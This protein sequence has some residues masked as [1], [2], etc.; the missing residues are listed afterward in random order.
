M[1]GKFP[2]PEMTD[3]AQKFFAMFARIEFAMKR[4]PAF[5]FDNPLE[6]DWTRLGGVL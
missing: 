3:V 6:P 4:C 5:R 1:A 2:I